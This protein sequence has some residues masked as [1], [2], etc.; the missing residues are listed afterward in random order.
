MRGSRISTSHLIDLDPVGTI[1]L[2]LTGPDIIAEISMRAS[3]S[4][5]FPCEIVLEDL[6]LGASQPPVIRR[7]RK[8]LRTT[9]PP[10]LMWIL[11][12]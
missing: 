1:N 5:E 6:Q 4:G 10:E 3:E 11:A 7:T 12:S 8:V 9:R 2:A